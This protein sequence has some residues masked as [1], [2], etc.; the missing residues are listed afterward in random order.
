[1]S[2]PGPK[3]K[4][5]ALELIQRS[6]RKGNSGSSGKISNP[7]ARRKPQAPSPPNGLGMTGLA[8]WK[9]ICRKL[10]DM[11]V[12]TSLDRA[13]L[14][15]YCASYERWIASTVAIKEMVD[16]APSAPLLVSTT[17][18][19]LVQNPLVGIQRRAAMDM[20]RFAAELGMTPSSRTRLGLPDSKAPPN[21]WEDF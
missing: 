9:R 7:S 18:G 16:E 6:S 2:I 12:I 4:L 5:S 8:E 14:G 21:H 3:P 11:G 17:N 15:A 10:V 19:N 1:M 20:V 13:V